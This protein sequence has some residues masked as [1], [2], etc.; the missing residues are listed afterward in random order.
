MSLVT[1]LRSERAQLNAQLQTLAKKDATGTAL[2]AD[3]LEQFTSLETQIND[4]TAKISRAEAAERI[5]AQAAVPVNEGA[6]GIASPPGTA[7]ITVTD[8]EP[9]G[10]KMAQVARLLASASGNQMQAA[11]MAQEGGYGQDI[12]QTLNTIT[13]GAGG[14]LIPTNMSSSVI[15]ALRPKS[16]VRSMG[17]VSLPLHNGNMTLPRIKSSTVVGYI[18]ADTDIP[19]TDMTFAD[20]KL[21]AKS[22]GA[23]VPISNDLLAF[24]G[25]NPGVDSIVASDLVTSLGLGEDLHFIRSAGSDILPKGLRYWALPA[26]V[27]TAPEDPD[28]QEIDLFFG[29]LM[30]RLEA[31]NAD[32]ANC[33]WL[34][35]PRTIRWLQSLRDGNGNKAYPEINDGTFKGYRF[36]LSTQIPVNLGVGGDESEV[37]FVDFADCYIG[38]TGQYSM[39]YSTEASYKNAN[40][41]VISAFQ[42]NQTLIRIIAKNDFAPRHVES[43]AIGVAVKWGKGM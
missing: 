20:M 35:H 38:E 37:Y 17:A 4:L 31:A 29:G 25:V 22:M 27:V 5:N 3:E 24:Q 8:N 10:A 15:P 14:V 41:D 34:M 6:R 28:L 32:M 12:V 11:Q 42:R 23:F 13:P 2:S 21:Q 18:G 9:P 33:G 1:Q 43:I 40:G 7:H 39:A 30:L 26:N 16:I 36:A 19:V